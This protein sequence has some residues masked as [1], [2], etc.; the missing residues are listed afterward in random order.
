MHP[1][2]HRRLIG[3]ALAGFLLLAGAAPAQVNLLWY[4]Q[5]THEGRIYVFNNPN[6]FKAWEGS[7][8]LGK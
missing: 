4:K 1:F 2:T 5:V 7:R 3:I 6:D 8:E